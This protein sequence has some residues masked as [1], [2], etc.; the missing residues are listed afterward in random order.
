[1]QRIMDEHDL[2]QQKLCALTGYKQSFVSLIM[3]GKSS[4]PEG[5][6]VKLQ[7]ALGLESLDGYISYVEISK[8]RKVEVAP[9]VPEVKQ[10][11]EEP[12]EKTVEQD[13]IERLVYLLNKSELRVE[14]L[15]AEIE[16]LK[17]ELASKKD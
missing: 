4:V 11:V 7:T 13:T 17:A 14:K 6:I 2:N 16:Q 12:N 15:E 1:M 5:F 8:Q 10:E 9:L 3:R